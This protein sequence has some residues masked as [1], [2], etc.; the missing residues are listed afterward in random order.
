M[1][2]IEIL[3]FSTSFF[4]GAINLSPNK[5]KVPQADRSVEKSA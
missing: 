1:D 3:P 4:L 2:D 5:K